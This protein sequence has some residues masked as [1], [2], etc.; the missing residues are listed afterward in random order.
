M[1]IEYITAAHYRI[2]YRNGTE[3]DGRDNI[4]LSRQ[5]TD[6][7]TVYALHAKDLKE[8]LDLDE[9]F[10][11][12]M[13]SNLAPVRMTAMY[14]LNDWWTRPAFI[15]TYAEIPDRTQVLLVET[16]QEY[17]VVL[18]L[19]SSQYKAELIPGTENA[20]RLRIFSGVEDAG[21]FSAP[22]CL[23]CTAESPR[24]AVE[25]AMK[26]MA[27]LCRIPLRN[28]RKMPA[29]L[30]YLGWCSWDAF[31]RDVSAEGLQNKAKE[32][33]DKNIPVRWFL[34]DDGW[35]TTEGM[36]LAAYQPD[37][38]KF[39]GGFHSVIEQ[40]RKESKVSWFG[41]WHAVCGFWEGIADGSQLSQASCIYRTKDGN[42]Y[43]G[44]PH[45]EDFYQKWY[46]Y[47]KA[48]G[49]VKTDLK[50]LAEVHLSYV[51]SIGRRSFLSCMTFPGYLKKEMPIG[52]TIQKDRIQTLL[53]ACTNARDRLLLLLLAETGYRIGEILGIRYASD[54]DLDT[55]EVRV[56]Y[57]EDNE[58]GARAKN[59]E[60]RTALISPVAVSAAATY[61][62][63]QQK[64]LLTQEYLFVILK[65]KTRGRPLTIES[66]YAMLRRLEKKTGIQATPHMLRHYFANERRKDGWGLELISKA[67]GHRSIATTQRYLNI[68]AEELVQASEAYYEKH[69]SM[70]QVGDLF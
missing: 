20:L 25:T 45:A 63:E 27:G 31:Y 59:A 55:G 2:R 11:V 61:L 37:D 7:C 4:T 24:T 23:F 38:Q 39:P 34:I 41:V 40:I 14:M 26:T 33:Q 9:A 66:V 48:E 1:R 51:N 50:V 6:G 35:L 19:V 67:L 60:E 22:V 46:A 21:D 42:L 36:K 8:P 53:H 29:M 16:E 47:L 15:H 57:R 70:I 5:D 54:L 10:V 12:T 30:N 52:R 64:L 13:E 3:T 17:A 32:L 49:L 44:G 62:A 69:G 28:E 56:R 43:P 58:N 18:P 65:G 68:E